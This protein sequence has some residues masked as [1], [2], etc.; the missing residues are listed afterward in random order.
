M[1]C[2]ALLVSPSMSQVSFSVSM[3]KA[4]DSSFDNQSFEPLEI[5]LTSE[6]GENKK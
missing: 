5:V 3:L 1:R 6:R 2:S 4:R